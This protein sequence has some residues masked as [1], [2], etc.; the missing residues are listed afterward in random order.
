MESDPLSRSKSSPVLL[1]KILFYVA[2]S[3]NF[4]GLS[5]S[6]VTSSIYLNF[7]GVLSSPFSELGKSPYENCLNRRKHAFSASDLAISGRVVSRSIILF[8]SLV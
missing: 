7:N 8:F 1:V 6:S 2:P 3:L 4:D 5:S